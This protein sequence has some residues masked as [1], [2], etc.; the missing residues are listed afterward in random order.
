MRKH[1]PGIAQVVAH[2]VADVRSEN[3]KVFTSGTAVFLAAPADFLDRPNLARLNHVAHSLDKRR[4]THLVR[5]LYFDAVTLD[6]CDHLVGVGEVLGK[7]F[8]QEDV[9]PGARH[10]CDHLD[11]LVK[12]TR[13]DSHEVRFLFLEHL[14]VVGVGLTGSCAFDGLGPACRVRIGDRRDFHE[15][16][17]LPDGIEPVSIVAMTGVADDTDAILFRLGGGGSR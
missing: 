9:T 15:I 6:R 17:C 12:P 5:H 11:S 8:F 14:V 1:P 16:K 10:G 3:D 7:G 2:H 13:S 4:L